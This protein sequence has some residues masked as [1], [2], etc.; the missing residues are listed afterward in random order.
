M[1]YPYWPL[2]DLRL[3]I[4]DLVLRPMTEPDLAPLAD[5]LPLDVETNPTLP[6]FEG[7]SPAWVSRGV[8]LSQ[9]YWHSMGTWSV[10]AWNLGFV[11]LRSGDP[12]GVQRLEGTEFGTKRTVDSASWLAESSRGQGVGKLM[13]LAVLALA[14]EHLGAEFAE[15]S[16][17]QDNHASLGVSRALGYVDNGRTRH[18]DRGRVDDMVRMRL[19]R[20][21]WRSTHGSHGVRV[22]N[23]EPCLPFFGL[24]SG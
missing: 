18:A 3:R 9:E 21:S 4:D 22:E 10:D 23:L 6:V 11:V 17:W 16:A 1:S 2:W 12:V 8:N 13:R 14:F 19:D 5:L 24:A 20:T 7:L 15:T